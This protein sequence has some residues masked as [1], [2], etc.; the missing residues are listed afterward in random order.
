MN[1]SLSVG[2]VL[3]HM[4]QSSVQEISSQR[5][6]LHGETQTLFEHLK[7]MLGGIGYR[8]GDDLNRFHESVVRIL[9]RSKLTFQETKVLHGFIRKIEDLKK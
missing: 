5:L 4:Y 9:N 8:E 1:L 7:R 6:A 3:S 2:V